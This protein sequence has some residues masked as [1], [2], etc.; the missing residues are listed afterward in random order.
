MYNF[1]IDLLK[2]GLNQELSLKNRD[3]AC[4][5]LSCTKIWLKATTVL[6]CCPHHV[7]VLVGVNLTIAYSRMTSILRSTK[8]YTSVKEAYFTNNQY[9]EI[10]YFHRMALGKR[11]SKV[12]SNWHPLM[13]IVCR[14]DCMAEVRYLPSPKRWRWHVFY[15]KSMLRSLETLL[16]SRVMHW[17]S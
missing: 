14:P 4:H 1:L 9:L 6:R 12:I 8:W 5:H 13:Y 15:K 17:H 16:A 7:Y 11:R 3:C 10:S 2:L